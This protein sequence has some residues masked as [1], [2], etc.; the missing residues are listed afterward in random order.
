MLKKDRGSCLENQFAH[1]NHCFLHHLSFMNSLVC[2]ISFVH[3]RQ[4]FPMPNPLFNSMMPEEISSCGSY[5]SN[6]G[7]EVVKQSQIY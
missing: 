7:I 2:K 3:K 1:L 5:L 4:Y 6:G